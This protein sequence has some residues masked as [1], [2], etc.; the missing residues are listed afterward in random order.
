MDY[1]NALED[2]PK[3]QA[4]KRCVQRISESPHVFTDGSGIS[5]LKL[6][7]ISYVAIHDA[8]KCH[9]KLS[10]AKALFVDGLYEIQR[11]YNFNKKGEDNELADAP[12]C[13]AGTFNKL[14]EKLHG[15]HQDVKVEFITHAGATAKFPKLVQYHTINYLETIASPSCIKD[16]EQVH[17]LLLSLDHG[18]NFE[19]IW[20]NISK[21]VEDAIWEEFAEAYGYHREDERFKDLLNHAFVVNLPNIDDIKKQLAA[22]DGCR[23]YSAQMALHSRGL[24][25]FAEPDSDSK[26]PETKRLR[27]S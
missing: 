23:L 17:S 15:I 16:Y 5:T 20:A 3:H 26:P 27:T 22:S 9:A 12:I 6:L 25:L 24:G 8:S 4:A 19:E 21:S 11:G 13:S 10:D 18:D 2:S 14:M 1:L 7:A